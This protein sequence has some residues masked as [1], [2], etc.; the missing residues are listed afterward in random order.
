MKLEIFLDEIKTNLEI[1][2][3]KKINLETDLIS[4]SEWDS[5]NLLILIDLIQTKLNVSIDP[6]EIKN[7][8]IIK[9]L[10]I[11]IEKIKGEKIFS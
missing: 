9:D 11:K 1:I 6:E 7:E 8:L 3:I 10:I 4:L 2:S 5:L